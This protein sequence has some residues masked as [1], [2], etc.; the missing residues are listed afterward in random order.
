MF[1]KN[2]PGE[3]PDAFHR[4]VYARIDSL[5]EGDGDDVIALLDCIETNW[6]DEFGE[7]YG[8]LARGQEQDDSRLD[9]SLSI[10]TT[11]FAPFKKRGFSE[12]ERN[13]YRIDLGFPDA[14]EWRVEQYFGLFSEPSERGV[15]GIEQVG[16]ELQRQLDFLAGWGD[17]RPSQERDIVSAL[18]R[19]GDIDSIAIYDVGQGAATALLSSGLPV[20]YFDLGGSAIG[21]WRSFPVRLNQFC[22][23]Q[24]PPVVLSHWDWDHWSSAVRDPGNAI[25]DRVWILPLQSA[26]GALGAVHA[27][28]LAM[29]NGRARQVLWWD[30]NLTQVFLPNL[31]TTIM[32]ATGPQS[33]RNESGLAIVVDR[34]GGPNERVLLPGDASFANLPVKGGDKFHHIMVPHHGGKTQLSVLPDHI[35]KTRGHVIYSYGAGNIFLHPRADTVKAHRPKWKKNAH[36]AIRDEMGLG[37]LGIDLSGRSKRFQS[38]RCGSVH[39]QLGIRHWI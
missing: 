19:Q 35:I 1:F 31:H 39:C 28:F 2:V 6:I 11:D 10:I 38:P 29:L 18:D 13:W 23:T 24:D 33:S 15:I 26:A 8:P 7:N 9:N 16:L 37:H 20:M 32:R 21:N 4:S 12:A 14:S 17:A 22:F 30:P 27:R 36:T 34:K 25:D 5:E 3:A